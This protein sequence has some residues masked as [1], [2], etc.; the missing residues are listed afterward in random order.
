MIKLRRFVSREGPLDMGG[1]AA[2]ITVNT[3]AVAVGG[4]YRRFGQGGIGF[5]YCH[6]SRVEVAGDPAARP[7][8]DYVLLVR[9]A[10]MLAIAATL[11]IRRRKR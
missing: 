10:W 2:T 4:S 6:P 7:I 11:L 8:H 9:F 1:R 3:W 5:A